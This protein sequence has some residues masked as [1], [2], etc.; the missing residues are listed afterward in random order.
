MCCFLAEVHHSSL[1]LLAMEVKKVQAIF[2]VGW[3]H[4]DYCG[5]TGCCGSALYVGGWRLRQ[6][7][8]S[9]DAHA[10]SSG[11]WE[12]QVYHQHLPKVAR[13]VRPVAYPWRVCK[14]Q[15][16]CKVQSC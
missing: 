12:L 9:Q 3:W 7:L 1:S 10:A 2:V 14:E 16:A 15:L 8:T 11:A 6:L 5:A 4:T 13:G